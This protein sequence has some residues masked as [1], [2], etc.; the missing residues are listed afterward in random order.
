M[1]GCGGKGM[2]VKIPQFIFNASCN[3][4]DLLYEKGGKEVDRFI[5]DFLFYWYMLKD[6]NIYAK[7]HWYVYPF[8]WLFSF[9]WATT[10]ILGVRIGGKKYFNYK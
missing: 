9:V 2:K 8:A 10:Y 1:N 6:V 5:A 4:H 7:K 3:I